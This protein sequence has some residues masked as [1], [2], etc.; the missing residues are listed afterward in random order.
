MCGVVR[1]GLADCTLAQPKGQGGA[2]PFSYCCRRPS[3]SCGM[4][5]KFDPTTATQRTLRSGPFERPPRVPINRIDAPYDRHGGR[6]D[7]TL[8]SAACQGHHCPAPAVAL[9]VGRGAF[10]CS[11]VASSYPLTH[12]RRRLSFGRLLQTDLTR[13][14][15]CFVCGALAGPAPCFFEATESIEARTVWFY[16]LTP[17]RPPSN[18]THTQRTGTCQIP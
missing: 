12:R 6:I 3:S 18:P 9:G 15:T 4:M 5:H 8:A 1:R 7:P 13:A 11:W 10:N 17:L 14:C 2:P 16:N